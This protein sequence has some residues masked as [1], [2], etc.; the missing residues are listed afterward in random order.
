MQLTHVNVS[1]NV[2]K[3]GQPHLLQS[4]RKLMSYELQLFVGVQQEMKI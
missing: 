3:G 4:H 2:N 1:M